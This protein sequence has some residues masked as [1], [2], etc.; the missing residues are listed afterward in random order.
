MTRE[1]L[2]KAI[3]DIRPNILK[4]EVLDTLS[5][6]ELDSIHKNNRFYKYYEI[7]IRQQKAS[8]I[9]YVYGDA[10]S[11]VFLYSMDGADFENLYLTA[12]KMSKEE[13][14]KFLNETLS[15]FKK[16]AEEEGDEAFL[17]FTEEEQIIASGAL[18][19]AGLL[20]EEEFVTKST[21][22]QINEI[23]EKIKHLEE[24]NSNL[25]ELIEGETNWSAVTDFRNEIKDNN[26]AIW[27]LR[28]ELN[29]L[30]LPTSDDVA[31]K[32]HP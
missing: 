16:R 25:E 10:Y 20:T 13:F 1:E 30:M 9:R 5:D 4:K 29:K 17:A 11:D 7:I 2:I 22:F 6:I 24:E 32:R 21:L 27:K 26:Y 8:V 31:R 3:L 19:P 12:I 15:D 18:S 14:E 28:E 23:T